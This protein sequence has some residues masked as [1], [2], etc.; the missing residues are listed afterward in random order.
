MRHLTEFVRSPLH[1][2]IER[3][4][5]A[6]AIQQASSQLKKSQKLRDS[7]V[8]AGLATDPVWHAEHMRLF[9]LG[10]R[11]YAANIATRD[12]YFGYFIQ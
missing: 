9:Q 12:Q 2:E 11:I 7:G 3:Y 5:L 8:R 6:R 10:A 4:Q 1:K